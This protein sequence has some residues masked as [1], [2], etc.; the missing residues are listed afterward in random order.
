MMDENIKKK[1]QEMSI[2]KW[3]QLIDDYNT[4]GL[5]L[6]EWCKANSVGKATYY[7]YLRLIRKEMID[8]QPSLM[9]VKNEPSFVPVHADVPQNDPLIITKGNV[10][11]EFDHV[12]DLNTIMNMIRVLLC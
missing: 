9:Q 1:K 4:S 11:I 2:T 12:T 8:D 7:K 5:T 3:K 10:R 6:D